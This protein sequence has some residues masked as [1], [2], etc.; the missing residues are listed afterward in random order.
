MEKMYNKNNRSV[1]FDVLA[2][3]ILV[4]DTNY[5]VVDANQAACE[6]VKLSLDQIIGQTCHQVSHR[7]QCPCWEIGDTNCPVKLS[8]ENKRPIRV[9]HEHSHIPGSKIEEIIATPLFDTDGN[10]NYIIEEIRELS[11]LL[12]TTE[13]KLAPENMNNNLQGFIPICAACKKIRDDKGLWQQFEDYISSQTD[14]QFTHSICPEC[15]KARYPELSG[16]P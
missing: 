12:Q 16:N 7:N 3:P 4:I 5:R 13:N 14:A 6:L 10:V 2:Q 8:I 1:I 11:N 15:I 9:V